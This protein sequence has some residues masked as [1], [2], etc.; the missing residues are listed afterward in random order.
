MKKTKPR[1]SH[2]DHAPPLLHQDAGL[3]G[4]LIHLHLGLYQLFAREV[5][6]PVGRLKLLHEL[7]HA[8]HAGAGISDLAQRLGVT[9]ALVTRQ[10]Q[11]LEAEGW[12]RRKNAPRDG[13]RSLALLSARGR[14]EGASIHARAHAFEASLLEGMTGEDL[15]A[16]ARVLATVL[17]RVELRLKVPGFANESALGGGQDVGREKGGNHGSRR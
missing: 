15:A 9:P 17:A 14:R 1:H 4:E 8:G 7:L 6:C 12:V 3:L 13:R 5:G 10:V 16:A 2:P 11:E